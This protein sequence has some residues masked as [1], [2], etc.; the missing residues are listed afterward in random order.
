[1]QLFYMMTC[2]FHEYNFNFNEIIKFLTMESWSY[3][4]YFIFIFVE[5]PLHVEL[6]IAC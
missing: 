3:I 6:F 4:L 5:N 2:A 1:M